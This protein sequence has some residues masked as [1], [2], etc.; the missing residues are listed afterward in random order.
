MYI[1]KITKWYLLGRLCLYSYSLLQFW[2]Y[3]ELPKQFNWSCWIQLCCA[4]ESEQNFVLCMDVDDRCKNY[5]RAISKRNCPIDLSFQFTFLLYH[6]VVSCRRKVQFRHIQKKSQQIVWSIDKPWIYCDFFDIERYM[7]TKRVVPSSS[8]TVSELTEL[9]DIANSYILLSWQLTV[10][11]CYAARG[12]GGSKARL[13][14]GYG[15]H[16]TV[17]SN[18]LSVKNCL[19][20]H[21][22]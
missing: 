18:L 7:K 15:R 2:S 4:V 9:R 21:F 13:S 16:F 3:Q 12:S 19:F 8:W 6:F 10:R 14:G 22:W 20:F 17:I 5:L 11:S 1:T